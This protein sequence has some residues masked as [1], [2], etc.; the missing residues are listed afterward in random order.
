MKG[1]V[2]VRWEWDERTRQFLVQWAASQGM[3]IECRPPEMGGVFPSETE[4]MEAS[5][6]WAK[7]I[8]YTY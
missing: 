1:V 2:Q 7:K 4:E 8:Q 3:S 5:G 6:G